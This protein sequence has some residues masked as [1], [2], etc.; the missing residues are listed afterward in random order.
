MV[1]RQAVRA[2]VIAE[3]F[4]KE[5]NAAALVAVAK[6][7]DDRAHSVDSTEI[8][9]LSVDAKSILG[10]FADFVQA[11][12][13]VLM[14]GRTPEA[15]GGSSAKAEHE[16]SGAEEALKQDSDPHEAKLL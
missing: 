8:Q 12:R 1:S 15:M 2:D 14:N 16:E 5:H 10:V 9:T 3:Y 7:L 6:E 11:K 13:A 4:T